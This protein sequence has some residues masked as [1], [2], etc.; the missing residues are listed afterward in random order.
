MLQNFSPSNTGLIKGGFHSIVP[1]LSLRLH[2]V[3]VCLEEGRN[4]AVTSQQTR[5]S[6]MVVVFLKKD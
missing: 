5:S 4:T 3:T 6:I 2:I 1:V